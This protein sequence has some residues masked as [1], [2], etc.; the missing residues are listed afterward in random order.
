MNNLKQ[1]FRISFFYFNYLLYLITLLVRNQTV[2]KMAPFC[3]ISYESI[4][5]LM[6]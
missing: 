1:T 3:P 6:S 2:T 4:R 5:Y